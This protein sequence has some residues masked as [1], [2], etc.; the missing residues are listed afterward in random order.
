M[1]KISFNGKQILLLGTAHISRESVNE[2]RQAIQDFK[3]DVVGIELDQQR[4]EQLK[5]KKKWDEKRISQVIKEGKAQLFLLNLFLASLQRRLGKIVKAKPGAE[6]IAAYRLAENKKIPVALLDR[7]I[8]ITMNRAMN[9]M[10]LMEK[11][12]LLLS[13]VIGLFGSEEVLS[14]T[15][16]KV[17]EL[18][19]KDIMTQAMNELAREAPSIKEVLVDERDLFIANRLM[20]LPFKKILAVVG[21]G[22]VEGI[23]KHLMQKNVVDL[24]RIVEVKKKPSKLR[25]L[26]WLIPLLLL[27]FLALAFFTKGPAKT[28]ELFA[29]WFLITG[30]F[31]ALGTLVAGGHPLSILVSFLAAPFTTIHPLLAAGWFAGYVELKL[32]SPKVKDFN[33]LAK[34]SSVSDFF[35]NQ[36]TRLLLI[37]ALT[38]LGATIGVVIAFPFLVSLLA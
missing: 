19:K 2:V 12:K 28:I 1:E 15:K 23:K 11:A 13:L 8:R 18:K 38:N 21:M 31:S 4:F 30:V 20:Q 32:R 16:E 29:Y 6:M 10:S 22:H 34:L 7:D 14:L 17:E 35:K 26:K 5:F 27:S 33:E 24:A 9:K 36:V 25:H 37:I 3:P